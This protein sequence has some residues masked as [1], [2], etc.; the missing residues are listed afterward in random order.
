MLAHQKNTALTSRGFYQRLDPFS[1]FNHWTFSSE[2][3]TGMVEL[4]KSTLEAIYS[5]WMDALVSK[6][7]VKIQP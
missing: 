6:P 5:C 3:N 2:Q 1:F 4:I 7:N